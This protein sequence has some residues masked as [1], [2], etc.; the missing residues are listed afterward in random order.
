MS[1]FL[2]ND[3]GIVF[4]NKIYDIVESVCSALLIVAILMLFVFRVVTVS[5]SSMENTL[6]E[7]DRIIV[8]KLFYTP[9][10]GDIIVTDSS[11]SLAKPLVKRII[12]VGGDKIK[13]DFSTGSVYV[14]DELLEE[15]YIKEPMRTEDKNNIEII[16]P[17]GY[18]FLMGDNRNVS[19]DS[20]SADVGPVSEKCILGKAIFRFMP[21]SK[22]GKL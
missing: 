16:V 13:V 7:N 4:M 19:L 2:F 6:I 8:T 20:R 9:E 10:K 5:G 12:A 3:K 15:E 18:V 17:E 1:S 11:N 22:I 21:F 14:N